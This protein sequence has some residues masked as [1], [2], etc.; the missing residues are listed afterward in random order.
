MFEKNCIIWD[1]ITALT[2]TK[3]LLDLNIEIDLINKNILVFSLKNE[4]FN[5]W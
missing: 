1:G 3:V 4:N 2:L 5:P